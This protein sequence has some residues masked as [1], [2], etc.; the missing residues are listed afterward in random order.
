MANGSSD[1]QFERPDGLASSN[2][3][4]AGTYANINEVTPIDA[5][6]LA[7]PSSP[8]TAN[9]YEV[10]LADV[11]PPHVT[12]GTVVRYRYAKSGNNSGKTINLTVE[13]RQGATLIATA[14]HP[15]IPGVSGSGWQPA[16]ITLTAGQAALITNV[17][18]LRLRF[19]PS[20]SG[21]GQPR[22]AQISWAEVQLPA[23]VDPATLFS[24]GYDRLSRL[25]SVTGADGPRSYTHDPPG[26]RLTKVAGAT[27]AY[28]YDRADRLLTAGATAVTVN[29]VG[30]ITARGT[31][32]F[33]YDQAN[34]LT[35]ATVAGVTETYT[36]DGDGVRFSRQVGA[37]PRHP[38]RQRSSTPGCRSRSTTAPASTS[39]AT[40]SPTPCPARRLEVYHAD[41]LG[42]V[43]AI[44]DA[45]GAVTATYRTDE[46][47]LPTATTGTTTQPFTFT[48]EPRDATGLT[49]LRAR[50]YD[51]TLGRFMSRDRGQD[52]LGSPGSL[53]SYVY[54]ESNPTTSRDPSGRVAPAVAIDASCP[55][56]ARRR[57][58]SVLP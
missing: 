42:S 14:T 49:Y 35:S 43:R 54:V 40:A 21:G 17:A 8:T 39:G 23:T 57:S 47:G 11:S 12:T 16:T 18:D 33:A 26:N 24:Y 19:R 25:T 30:N 37:G 53:N 41:R 15:N 28:A 1:L 32:T 56:H 9:Y 50:Y 10:S 55:A 6:F 58:E 46:F 4:W 13:L 3:T 7:S 2:G 27:T 34:R 38:L 52:F 20:S 48:G 36:Y 22:E 44:T 45:T 31:D 29:A 51:P 5:T